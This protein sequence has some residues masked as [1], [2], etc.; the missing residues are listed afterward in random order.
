MSKEGPH[1]LSYLLRLWQENDGGVICQGV[2]RVVW[3][4][5]LENSLTGK[6]QGFRSLDELF[7]FLRQ[8]TGVVADGAE[9]DNDAWH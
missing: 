3:R 5:S 2:E 1:Y 6:R 7:T 9:R 4:A 8:E